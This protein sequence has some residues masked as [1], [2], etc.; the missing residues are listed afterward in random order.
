M[1]GNFFSNLHELVGSFLNKT[2]RI[3]GN[4]YLISFIEKSTRYNG[5]IYLISF[6]EKSTRYNGIL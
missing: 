5:N 1:L 2:T 4:I 3:N 6:I